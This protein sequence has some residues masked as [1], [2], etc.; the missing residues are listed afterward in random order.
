MSGVAPTELWKRGQKVFQ[1]NLKQ[2]LVYLVLH[3]VKI[4]LCFTF[5]VARKLRVKGG[6]VDSGIA[7]LVLVDALFQA[8]GVSLTPYR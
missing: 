6:P 5:A 7:S 4:V 3:T 8:F 2:L 1:T